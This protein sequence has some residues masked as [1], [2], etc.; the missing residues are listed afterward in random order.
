[1]RLPGQGAWCRDVVGGHV[2]LSRNG[3]KAGRTGTAGSQ[4]ESTAVALL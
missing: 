1:M 2:A 4:C 3:K